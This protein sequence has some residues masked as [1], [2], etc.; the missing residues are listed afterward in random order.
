MGAKKLFIG[1]GQ[2]KTFNTLEVILISQIKTFVAP[3]DSATSR[4]ERF[5]DFLRE[6]SLCAKTRESNKKIPPLQY[7][8]SEL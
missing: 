5:R 4:C 2:D 8:K 6:R 3:T 1:R 7:A